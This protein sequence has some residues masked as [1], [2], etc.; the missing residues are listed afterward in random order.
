MA[1]EL[2]KREPHAGNINLAEGR[3]SIKYDGR[4]AHIYYVCDVRFGITFKGRCIKNIQAK[5]NL[6][7]IGDTHPPS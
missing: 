6:D 4:H 7:S 1:P 3:H 2:F 5:I